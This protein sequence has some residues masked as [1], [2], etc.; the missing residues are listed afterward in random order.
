MPFRRVRDAVV[1]LLTGAPEMSDQDLGR[2]VRAPDPY[3]WRLP[4]PYEARWRRWAKRCRAARCYLP[5][6]REEACWAV[7]DRPQ[8]AAAWPSEDDVVRP[9]VLRP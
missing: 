4:S 7:P 6:P 9:Y 8:P 3:V 2:E 1:R 5:F